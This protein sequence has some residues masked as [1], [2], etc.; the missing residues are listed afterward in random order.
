MGEPQNPHFCDF[1][2]FGRVQT[3]QYQHYLSSEAPGHLKK[4]KKQSWNIFEN[5]IFVNTG[6]KIFDVVES[7]VYRCLFL[8]F[9]GT[10]VLSTFLKMR[11]GK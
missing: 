4:I 9:S 8:Q 7:H 1:G 10:Y 6:V 5:R 11:I 2:I 3:P